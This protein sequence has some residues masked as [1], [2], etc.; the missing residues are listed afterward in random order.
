MLTRWRSGWGAQ[1]CI[2]ALLFPP[3]LLLRESLCYG[4]REL[5]WQHEQQ[6]RKEG[7]QV[8]HRT[9]WVSNCSSRCAQSGCEIARGC[10]TAG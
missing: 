8:V 2:A 10:L 3:L 5:H 7:P 9:K 6:L 4:G 1:S